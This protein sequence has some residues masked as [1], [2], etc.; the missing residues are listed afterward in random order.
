LVIF[1]V[2][3]FNLHAT[4]LDPYLHICGIWI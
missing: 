2:I 3:I 1:Q 4:V